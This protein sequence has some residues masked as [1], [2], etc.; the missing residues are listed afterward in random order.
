MLWV[1][2][3]PTRIPW[4]HSYIRYSHHW[5]N[6]WWWT[7]S[8]NPCT[9]IPPC[10]THITHCNHRTELTPSATSEGDRVGLL[11][12]VGRVLSDGSLYGNGQTGSW[13]I[14]KCKYLM[15]YIADLTHSCRADCWV[16]DGDQTSGCGCVEWY[17]DLPGSWLCHWQ[18]ECLGC[19]Y[20]NG[21]CAEIFI[22]HIWDHLN[23]EI[24][25]GGCMRNGYNMG[26]HGWDFRLEGIW[27]GRM[28]RPCP[29]WCM[30]SSSNS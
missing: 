19:R 15:G 7:T 17:S 3:Y 18:T 27:W 23:W 1:F 30:S 14:T 5:H 12:C 22:H 13:L 21:G 11:C 10:L 16:C 24:Y 20:R 28:N 9:Q 4:D 2:Q 8:T 29:C 6:N 25:N 26:C